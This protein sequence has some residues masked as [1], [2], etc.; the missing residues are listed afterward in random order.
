MLAIVLNVMIDPAFAIVHSADNL[1][2]RVF[3]HHIGRGAKLLLELLVCKPAASVVHP[4]MGTADE[5]GMKLG[6][7]KVV[8]VVEFLFAF[9]GND[10]VA[11]AIEPIDDLSGH[12][13][14]R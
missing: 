13:L 2:E 6:H 4:G 10:A 5:V 8:G 12:K 14:G 7:F 1:A 3:A 9:D 11:F